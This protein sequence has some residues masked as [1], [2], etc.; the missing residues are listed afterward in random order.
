MHM[1]TVFLGGWDLQQG[2]AVKL[3]TRFKFIPD[4]QGDLKVKLNKNRGFVK[5]CGAA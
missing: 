5:M 4:V 3:W 1:K 2:F